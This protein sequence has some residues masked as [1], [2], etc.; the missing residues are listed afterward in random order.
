VTDVD[1]LWAATLQQVM[2]RAAH[3]M[4]NALNGATINLEVVRSRLIAGKTDLKS[5]GGFA[6]AAYQQFEFA[7][8]WFESAMF[9][10][11]PHRGDGPADVAATLGHLAALLVPAAKADGIK[12]EVEGYQTSVTTSAPPMAVRLALASGLLALIK[13]GGGRCRLSGGPGAVVRFSHESAPV[14]DLDPALA[15][16][17]GNEHIRIRRS[18]K[19]LHIEFPGST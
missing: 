5:V 10:S 17:L 2:Q 14:G 9:L 7:T 4:R 8:A 12:L 11:R 15:S 3:E 1:T 13:E 18:D 6:D 16:A 19:D